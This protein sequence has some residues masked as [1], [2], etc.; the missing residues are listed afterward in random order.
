[1]TADNHGSRCVT[2]DMLHAVPEGLIIS[3][4]AILTPPQF[5]ALDKRCQAIAGRPL[6]VY[7]KSERPVFG[8]INYFASA[9]CIDLVA[10][11]GDGSGAW[12]EYGLLE[13]ASEISI[14][15]WNNAIRPEIDLRRVP[16][17]RIHEFVVWHEIGH[18]LDNYCHFDAQTKRC[19]EWDDIREVNEVLADRFAW[20]AMF[21]GERLPVREGCSHVDDWLRNWEARLEGFPRGPKWPIVPLAEVIPVEHL[22]RKIPWSRGV[23]TDQPDPLAKARRIYANYRRRIQNSKR[24]GRFSAGVTASRV[25]SAGLL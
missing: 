3:G 19:H 20:R 2:P 13:V 7:R 9:C 1:M 16:A 15:R 21:P 14:D 12:R 17:G 22:K 10:L 6:R 5:R 8:C 24:D 4:F 23:S 11:S 25:L 18:R